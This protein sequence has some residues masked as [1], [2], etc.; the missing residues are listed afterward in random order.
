MKRKLDSNDVPCTD[1]TESTQ[2]ATEG[3]EA[4]GLDSRLLQAVAREKFSKPTLVQ[5]KAIPEAFAGKDIL[6]I[7]IQYSVGSQLIEGSTCEDWVWKDCCIPSPHPPVNSPKEIR[8]L[9]SLRSPRFLYL[10]LI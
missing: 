9:I 3:F 4:F 5:V 1:V 8:K 2:P 7:F 10:R 6:G